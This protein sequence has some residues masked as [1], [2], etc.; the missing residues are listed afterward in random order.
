MFT[1]WPPYWNKSILSFHHFFL[2]VRIYGETFFLIL[3]L[4]ELGVNFSNCLHT[5]N[6]K[7]SSHHLVQGFFIFYFLFFAWVAFW[8]FQLNGLFL[9][10]TFAWAALSGFQLNK[11]YYALTFAWITLLCFQSN[12]PFFFWWCHAQFR[13]MR[14][15]GHIIITFLTPKF[16]MLPFNFSSIWIIWCISPD[17]HTCHMWQLIQLTLFIYSLKLREVIG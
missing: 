17:I 8:G 10:L 3:M 12:K 4:T 11:F 6:E 5:V 16:I 9:V 15:D 13:L 14:A 7:G 2:M 1:S